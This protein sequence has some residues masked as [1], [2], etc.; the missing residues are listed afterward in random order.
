MKRFTIFSIVTIAAIATILSSCKYKAPSESDLRYAED[1]A[2][3]AQLTA[4]GKLY[5]LNELLDSFMTEEGNYTS[6]TTLYR[7]RS[8]DSGLKD[9]DGNPIY[10]F[11]IDT[12]PADGPGIY[13]RGRVTTDDYGGNFYK[14]LVIQEVVEDNEGKHQETLRLSVDAGSISGM[15]PR[16]QMILIRCNGLAIGRYANQPQLCVPSY[17]NN[18]FANKAAEKIGWAPGRIPLARFKAATKL[19]GTPIP[20]ENLYYDFMTIKDINDLN[21]LRDLK[22]YRYEDGKLIKVDGIHYTGECDDNHTRNYCKTNGS[23]STNMNFNVFAPTTENQNFPQSRYIADASET[24]YTKISMSEYAKEANFYIPGAGAAV[25]GEA[26][27][28]DSLAPIDYSKPYLLA[29]LTINNKT[30][31]AVVPVE[32]AKAQQGWQVD[33]VIWLGPEPEDQTTERTGFVYTANGTWSDALGV[34]HCKE[35]SGSVKGI[36]GFYFDNARNAVNYPDD[37]YQAAIS[38][39]DLSDLDLKK[40]DGTVWTP[41]EYSPN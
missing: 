3:I 18:V 26:F 6:D 8:T 4:D 13:I 16:G 12:L 39:C 24:Y 25:E 32:F 14:A 27:T 40:A 31:Q 1:E 35:Y 41:I 28:Y 7:T 33:D 19:I 22:R 23:P 11:S 20:A 37:T 38:I 15:Y 17:N 2:T 5:T 36:L 30:I 29:N 34:I 21:N 9:A 10:L